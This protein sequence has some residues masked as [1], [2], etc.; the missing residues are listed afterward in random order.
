M[1]GAGSAERSAIIGRPGLAD[2]AA[3]GDGSPAGNL[4]SRSD[5]ARSPNCSRR[6]GYSC[7]IETSGTHEVRCSHSAWVTVSPKSEYEFAAV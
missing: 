7:Q 1:E 2:G 6:N 5:A 4:H 3:R